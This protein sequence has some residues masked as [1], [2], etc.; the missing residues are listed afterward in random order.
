MDRT[1]DDVKRDMLEPM[2]PDVT[3]AASEENQEALGMG[4]EKI[5]TLPVDTLIDMEVASMVTNRQRASEDWRRP[6]RLKWDQAWLDYKQIYNAANKKPWQS[7]TFMPLITRSV[8]VIAANMHGAI[9]GPEM[10]VE[11]EDRGRPDL[12][13]RIQKHNKIIGYDFEKC[14][15]KAHWTD[16]LRSLVL[17]GTAVGKVD[18]V[19]ES[20][21]VMVKERRKPTYID[22][23]L[24]KFGKNI[25]LERLVPKNVLVKDH[26][27][28][29]HKDLYDIYVQPYTEEF[30]KDFW[31]IE[32]S[33]ITNKELIDGSMNPD[34]YYRLSN[35][36]DRLLGSTGRVREGQDP[37][38]QIRR[39]AFLDY[40][41]NI[42]TLEPDVQ[43]ELL[44]YYGPVPTWFID[45]QLRNDPKKKYDT[46]PGWIWVVDGHVVRK[47]ISPW[48]D[49]EPPFVK[50][51]YIRV[52]NQ[53]YGIGVG[54]LLAGLQV[55][56]N[57]HRNLAID[58]IN[59]I[60]QKVTAVI[61][62]KVP[63][64]EWK[65]LK[66]EPA[67]L[68][69]FQGVDDVRKAVQTIEFPDMTKDVWLATQQIDQE[70]AE[71]SGAVRATLGVAGTQEDAGGTTFRGQLLNKQVATE[72]FMLYARVL[73]IC[74][75]GDAMKKFYQ[76][77]YQF[78][79]YEEI[80]SILGP[81]Q[82]KNVN[83]AQPGMDVG[84]D[85]IS[86]EDLEKVAK[87][88]PLGVLTMENK[89]VKLAQMERFTAQWMMEPWFKKYDMAR[90]E[91]IEMG[92][93]DPD[94]VLFSSEEMQKFNEFRKAALGQG[95]GLPGTPVAGNP[96]GATP[97]PISGG[98]GMTAGLP[99]P[100]MPA[101]GPGAKPS[102]MAGMS[103]G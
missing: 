25:E 64:E 47:R 22:S 97:S 66:A 38:K 94:Q 29:V 98:D 56:K 36:T 51:N 24:S 9:M 16:F 82:S 6:R 37:E 20:E 86:P 84:F 28:F 7:T 59:I 72:R 69:V 100:A 60:M 91:W 49:A 50:G 46:V 45:P 57:E 95:A 27:R 34:P 77:I 33:K 40:D 55:E 11:W 89:G 30:G 103:L 1:I 102:D 70:A 26:A 61:K 93:P 2:Y 73:E 80:D 83:P 101:V 43:H 99:N 44:E 35:I 92:L 96:M 14:K 75:L 81:S 19:R 76:R 52:P 15:F 12:A 4:A 31:V 5:L 18:Y 85:L 68:W 39:L 8:E 13:E 23:L 74:G 79:S 53:F 65:R 48:R 67:A 41:I 42:A 88:V 3:P 54:E 58:N 63:K 17:L 71:T 10:P 87:L 62:D 90:K 78:K 21:E 32:K